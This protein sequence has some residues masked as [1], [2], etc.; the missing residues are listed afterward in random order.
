MSIRPSIR[1]FSH[2]L[3]A[4]LLLL[5]AC[6]PSPEDRARARELYDEALSPTF[7]REPEKAIEHLQ[8][9]LRLDPGFVEA[10]YRIGLL[11]LA[12]KTDVSR[13]REALEATLE[14][15]PSHG[16]A[17]A[18]L[19]E[20]ELNHGEFEAAREHLE[21]A[22]QED[23]SLFFAWMHLGK[24]YDRLQRPEEAIDAF[25]RAAEIRE[26][27]SPHFWSGLMAI[28]MG[29]SGEAEAAFRRAIELAPAHPSA[30]H[31]LGR[32]LSERGDHEE[33]EREIEIHELIQLLT[34]DIRSRFERPELLER[35]RAA[36]RLL[37]LTPSS[38]RVENI[39]GDTLLQ[40]AEDTGDPT[41]RAEIL[42]QAEAA[43][44]RAIAAQ[45]DDLVARLRLRV[46]YQ[47]TG[48]SQKAAEITEELEEI[49]ARRSDPIDED[50][51]EAR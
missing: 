3:V 16:G 33:A 9:A 24:V 37:E 49:R 11:H 29:R 20:I 51:E 22:V 35:R 10:Q 40:L 34:G 36:L 17:L 8:E 43:Y 47:E 25:G 45:P 6:G 18:K 2:A 27:P 1:P 39:L 50:S 28:R 23:D 5:S 30:H 19:G 31:Q 46:L 12:N 4:A 44:R 21:R 7:Q 48:R 42:R 13:A 38:A 15:D 26:H 32:L 14:L 41:A